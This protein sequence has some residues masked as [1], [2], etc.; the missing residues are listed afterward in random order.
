MTDTAQNPWAMRARKEKAEALARW[1][2]YYQVTPAQAEEMG[3]D[4]WAALA[5]LANVRWKDSADDH[6]TTKAMA[7][8]CLLM[9]PMRGAG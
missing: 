2:R 1:L 8:G 4:G 9:T 5:A 7:I 3:E 6:K